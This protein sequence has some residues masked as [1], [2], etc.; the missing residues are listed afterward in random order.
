MRGVGVEPKTKIERVESRYVCERER[1]PV[2][3]DT[4][5]VAFFLARASVAVRIAQ[6]DGHTDER[7]TS[8]AYLPWPTL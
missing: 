5:I 7:G 2:E 4:V 6:L 3:D 1:S 8:G